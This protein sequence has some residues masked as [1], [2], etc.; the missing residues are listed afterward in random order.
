MDPESPLDGHSGPM[1]FL[2]LELLMLGEA[3]KAH[4]PVVGLAESAQR[5]PRG[6]VYS[7]MSRQLYGKA[8]RNQCE[9]STDLGK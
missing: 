1:K 5:A 4:Y 3:V 2:T 8:T 6:P 9:L 7:L